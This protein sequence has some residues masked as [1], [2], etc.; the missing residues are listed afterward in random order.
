MTRKSRIPAPLPLCLAREW[1]EAQL[2][3]LLPQLARVCADAG[4][5]ADAPVVGAG[6]GAFLAAELA[7]RA[8][9]PLRRYSEV[10]LRGT[11]GDASLAR[12]ADVCAPAVSVALLACERG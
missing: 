11:L 1:K 8:G 10:A 12:W 9:R 6:C 3:L 7:R 2:E 5:P 4:L